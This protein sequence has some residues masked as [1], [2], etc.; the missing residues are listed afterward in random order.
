M[1]FDQQISCKN[2]GIPEAKANRKEKTTKDPCNKKNTCLNLNH[3]P[4]LIPNP[5]IP[6]QPTKPAK[7]WQQKLKKNKKQTSKDLQIRA[8]SQGA[9]PS[10]A[11]EVPLS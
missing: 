6:D 3:L 10:G 8:L 9:T 7:Q 4:N 2:E 11:S 1:S 5:K